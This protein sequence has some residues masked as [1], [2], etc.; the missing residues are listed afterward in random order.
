MAILVS[1]PSTVQFT[2]ATAEP[3]DPAATPQNTGFTE[4][5]A[6]AMQPLGQ[7]ADGATASQK[8]A[9][10]ATETKLID[11]QI[12]PADVLLNAVGEANFAF[13]AQGAPIAQVTDSTK[14]IAE[15]GEQLAIQEVID[16]TQAAEL[17]AAALAAQ[18]ASQPPAETT[19]SQPDQISQALN[20][21][22]NAD[23][24]VLAGEFVSVQTNKLDLKAQ[25]SSQTSL[26]APQAATNLSVA[27]P[28]NG[29]AISQ[30]NVLSSGEHELQPNMTFLGEAKPALS[31]LPEGTPVAQ[32]EVQAPKIVGGEL[33]LNVVDSQQAQP[34][35]ALN[36]IASNAVNTGQISLENS[37]LNATTIQSNSSQTGI[38]STQNS[39][40]VVSDGVSRISSADNITPLANEQKSVFDLAQ[41]D[42]ARP[43]DEGSANPVQAG[44]VAPNEDGAKTN[45]QAL[46]DL[47]ITETSELHSDGSLQL[48]TAQAGE[49]L[50]GPVEKSIAS[51]VENPTEESAFK[52]DAKLGAHAPNLA[53][54]GGSLSTAQPTKPASLGGA[55]LGQTKPTSL[56]LSVEPVAIKES[57]QQSQ[58]LVTTEAVVSQT[59]SAAN[60]QELVVE[61]ALQTTIVTTLEKP[62]IR[63]GVGETSAT[64]ASIKAV[65]T[66][67]SGQ[68]VR[69]TENKSEIRVDDDVAFDYSSNLSS[70]LAPSKTS[71]GTD[72]IEFSQPV[73][74]TN[75][76]PTLVSISPSQEVNGIVSSDIAG[77][78]NESNSE[79]NQLPGTTST[80]NI[81]PTKATRDSRVDSK[82]SD[83]NQNS[84]VLNSNFINQQIV[85]ESSQEAL[86]QNELPQTASKG[87]EVVSSTFVNSLVGGPQRS[88]TTVMDWVALK[89]QESP[90]PVVPH[91][92][93]LDAGAVQVEIQRMVK[94]GG[95][96]VV[97]ELTPPDQSKF[98]IELKLDEV[99]G[100]YLRVEGVSDSTKTR[101]EQSAPQLQEQFLEMGLNLQLDMRQNKDSSSSGT[102]NWMPNEPGFDN[103]QLPEASAQTTRAVAAERARNNNGGQVYL[104]A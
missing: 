26:I 14:A 30:V 16:P 61:T 101:L 73:A 79:T 68:V 40:G 94:Q 35:D 15:T 87:F 65:N 11:L 1:N 93:R 102:A 7:Q 80:G 39:V 92:L 98:T 10:S 48:K 64:T 57:V 60:G 45:A 83:A 4:E 78:E 82:N 17:A 50:N 22:G 74:L 27:N 13:S 5:L 89:P 51:K 55:A 71:N 70:T 21:D 88:M 90:R 97:M 19:N 46:V 58:V 18:M 96:H 32:M 34:K 38:A 85:A 59:R 9:V 99:G 6:N 56:G 67:V 12:L 75:D 52:F 44:V 103:N 42:V 2:G 53:A 62:S 72:Q 24:S 76:K 23:P 77:L 104:Y 29:V 100:A 8:L 86:A 63:I 33:Q 81:E 69:Q 84:E 28:S 43:G 37:A 41:S 31:L 54:T 66:S 3:Q 20:S 36:Q 25:E 47:Q 91:E 49:V 95:G